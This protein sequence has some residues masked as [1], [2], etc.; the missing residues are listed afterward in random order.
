MVT[1]YKKKQKRNPF[2]DFLLLLGGVAILIVIIFLIV[3]NLRMYERKERLLSQSES[4]QNKIQETEQENIE[5]KENI[6][7]QDEGVY[8]EKIAR[9]ELNLQK[10]GE[11][12]VSFVMAEN[13]ESKEPKKQNLWQAWLGGALEWIKNK[14]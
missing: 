9:E 7:H 13:Q 14:F 3:A 10:E 1:N 2:L 11:T 8:V 4:I 5:L 12:V 6:A